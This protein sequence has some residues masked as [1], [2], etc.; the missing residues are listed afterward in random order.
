MVESKGVMIMKTT[1]VKME[2]NLEEI[3]RKIGDYWKD[4]GEEYDNYPG[5]DTEEEKEEWKKFLSNEIGENKLRILDAGTG[6]GF[7]ALPLAEMRHDVVGIDLSEGMLSRAIK[8]AKERGLNPDLRFGDAESL[9]FDDEGFDVVVSRWVLWTLIRP[10]KAI[11]E[12]MRVLKPGGQVYAFGSKEPGRK[13]RLNWFKA[14]LA[15]TAITVL[16]RRNAWARS[17]YNKEVKENLP[18]HYDKAGPEEKVELLKKAGFKDV[19]VIDLEEI[20][21]IHKEKSKEVPLRYRLI[22]PGN[23]WCCIKGRKSEGRG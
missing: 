16:E 5:F 8:K 1:E 20:N 10:D 3:K 17:D 14:N 2:T 23:E 21:K 6:T 7:L 9:D 12:W 13:G 18:L 19:Y 22:W 15:M 11:E 4:A